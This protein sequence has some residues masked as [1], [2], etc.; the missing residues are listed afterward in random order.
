RHRYRR[1]YRLRFEAVIDDTIS[2]TALGGDS[3]GGRYRILGGTPL[4][5]RDERTRPGPNSSP[6]AGPRNRHQCHGAEL[7]AIRKTAAGAPELHLRGPGTRGD[8]RGAD[9]LPARTA[10]P[11]AAPRGDLPAP[12]RRGR[13]CPAQPGPP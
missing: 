6:P 10:P 1:R 5:D 7:L 13:P 3:T 12:A 8:P 4:R 2:D 11:A 9:R